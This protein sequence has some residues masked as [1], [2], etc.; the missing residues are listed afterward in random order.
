MLHKSLD[1]AKRI[2]LVGSNVCDDVEAL[3]RQ[4]QL[5]IQP[6]TPEQAHML[7]QKVHEHRLEA[8]LTLALT[9][10]TRKGEIL[11]LRWQ[12]IDLQKNTL[13]V[14]HTVSYRGRNRFIEGVPKTEKSKRKITLPQFV[15][16]TLKRH[17]AMQL[18]TRLQARGNMG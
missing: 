6:L 14:R 4:A 8:V 17:H 1:H 7:L 9:T 16:E 18:E 13:Q 11:S 15:V 3:P 5:E 10:G 2:K 12:D